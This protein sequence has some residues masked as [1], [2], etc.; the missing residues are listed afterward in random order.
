MV[1]LSPAQLEAV[2]RILAAHVPGCEVRAFGSRVT[3]AAKAYSDLDLAVV[4]DRPLGLD[5]LG[6]LREAFEESELPIRVDL[7]EWGATAEGFRRVI[8]ESYEILQAAAPARS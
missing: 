6:R 4:A 7:I 5:V 8:E 1:D 3:G 2:K